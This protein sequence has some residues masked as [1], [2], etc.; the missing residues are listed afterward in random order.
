MMR[1][2]RLLPA[3]TTFAVGAM[4]FTAAPLSLGQ[5]DVPAA[6]PPATPAPAVSLPDNESLK[7]SIENFWHYGKIARYDV[8]AAEGQ[9]VLSQNTDPKELLAAFEAVAQGH[10]D[11]LDEWLLRWEGVDQMRDVSTQLITALNKGHQARRT[12]PKYIEQN[13]QELATNERG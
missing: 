4:F 7:D 11:N 5:A 6:P 3:L 12:D 9:R 10:H 8:A 2:P 13:I 1:L